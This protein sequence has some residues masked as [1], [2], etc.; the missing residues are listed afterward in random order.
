M[1][2]WAH[3]FRPNG[4]RGPNGELV[5]DRLMQ[6]QSD[7]EVP[8]LCHPGVRE[9]HRHPAHDG[10]DWLL[11]RMSGEGNLGRILQL[12]FDYG[13]SRLLGLQLQV[14]PLVNMGP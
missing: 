10:N 12:L 6:W 7:Q 4:Q 11:H 8:F 9:Y 13:S 5:G 14:S 1:P 3:L 2:P